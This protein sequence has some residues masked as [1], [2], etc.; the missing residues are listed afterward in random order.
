MIKTPSL[1]PWNI[2]LQPGRP[3]VLRGPAGCGKTT[4]AREIAA[5][6]GRFFEVA[7]DRL[8]QPMHVAHNGFSLGLPTCIVDVDSD[9]VDLLNLKWMLEVGKVV[10]QPPGEWFRLVGLPCFIICLSDQVPIPAW[11]DEL[12]WHVPWISWADYP[13]AEVAKKQGAQWMI[14]GEVHVYPVKRQRRLQGGQELLAVGVP[15][16]QENR[17]PSPIKPDELDRG[18]TPA[19]EALAKRINYELATFRPDGQPLGEC[20]SITISESGRGLA[21]LYILDAE[22]HD[23][24][25]VMRWFHGAGAKD[26]EIRHVLNVPSGAVVNGHRPDPSGRGP[27]PWE[28]EFRI[29]PA[30]QD[31][32]D[33]STPHFLAAT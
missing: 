12:G 9:V 5:A 16:H 13:A 25:R 17:Q 18:P 26:V 11:I 32:A 15:I 23:S 1:R 31:H 14:D 22:F 29:Q 33:A 2:K 30:S 27:R 20:T 6:H 8:L 7:A 4:L 3:L 19:E 28:V 24:Y 10:V 21:I